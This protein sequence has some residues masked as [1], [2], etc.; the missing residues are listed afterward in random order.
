MD[1]GGAPAD[2]GETAPRKLTKRFAS[3]TTAPLILAMVLPSAGACP[4]GAHTC[5][6][7]GVD[8]SSGDASSTLPSTNLSFSVRKLEAVYYPPDGKTYAYVDV[9]NFS[10]YFYPTS[11]SSEV[12]VFSSPDGRTGWQYHGIVIP[13][14]VNGSWDGGGVASPG[15]AVASDG[16]VVVGYTAETHLSGGANRGIG[17]AIAPH[18]LGPFT[19]Q[20]TP[21]ASPAGVCGGT[22]RCDDV[23]MQ[24]WP[25]DASKHGEIHLYHSVKGGA[26]APGAGIRHRASTDGGHAW[27]PS[28]L[29]LTTTLQP[30]T[31]PAE[32]IAGKYFPS[33]RL[34][35]G[36]GGMVLITD[37]GVGASPL[38]AYVS[39][40][41][42]NMTGFVAAAEPTL[43]PSELPWCPYCAPPSPPPSGGV[44]VRSRGGVPPKHPPRKGAW[45]MNQIGF[46][47]DK[48]GAIVGVRRGQTLAPVS[49][50][51]PRVL[52]SSCPR[53]LVSLVS[54]VCH[55]AICA[56]PT[57]SCSVHP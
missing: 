8:W 6:S 22:G 47:P 45:A 1:G 4:P 33:L 55:L 53:V 54:L 57:A 37:G 15:A 48:D 18:P 29:V 52:V 43:S 23:I 34:R 3:F 49:D 44:A 14:G 30:G 27:G 28:E 2:S 19:K 40:S 5:F 36:K 42:G 20:A 51:C 11:Y 7:F 50:P 26:P 31:E 16:S 38:H 9:V 17:V 13:R 12:G 24:S 25:G 21:L 41:P 56:C 32:T 46:V 39:S 10:D 35:G